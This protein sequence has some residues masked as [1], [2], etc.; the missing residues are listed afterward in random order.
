MT[1]EN[2]KEIFAELISSRS[3]YA[4]T[5]INRFQANEIKRRFEKKELSIG[6]MLEV[7]IECG[8]S[9]EITKRSSII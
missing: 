9:I 1:I 2:I 5:T 7:L 8:Y 4:E 3:W 6:R